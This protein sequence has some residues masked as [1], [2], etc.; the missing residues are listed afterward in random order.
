MN[1]KALIESTKSAKVIFSILNESSPSF[2]LNTLAIDLVSGDQGDLVLDGKDVWIFTDSRQHADRI[3]QYI[4][5]DPRYPYNRESQLKAIPR[6]KDD[7]SV[8]FQ[9]PS[10][11]KIQIED[12]LDQ[13]VQDKYSEFLVSK[14]FYFREEYVAFF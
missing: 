4:T 11:W 12:D 9:E 7:K 6:Y 10:S 3:I 14:Y 2:S 13:E 1:Y 8:D 5:Y